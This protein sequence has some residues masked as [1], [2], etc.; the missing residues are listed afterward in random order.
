M[1]HDVSG[2]DLLKVFMILA[3]VVI[4]GDCHPARERSLCE[5]R[6]V[7]KPPPSTACGR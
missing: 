5:P 4:A 1:R 2:F 7:A 3:A 6:A